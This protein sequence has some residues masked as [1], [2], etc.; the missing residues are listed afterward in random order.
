MVLKNLGR[1]MH[2]YRKSNGW[3]QETMAWKLKCA[4]ST[5]SGIETGK[6]CPSVKTFDKICVEFE[7][8]GVD[9]HELTM[10]ENLEF[11]KVKEELILA[12]NSKGK[13]TIEKKLEKFKKYM[14]HENEEHQK[15]VLLSDLVYMLKSGMD[16]EE[17]IERIEELFPTNHETEKSDMLTG[18]HF[19]KLEHFG[20]YLK[21][22]ALLETGYL[23]KAQELYELLLNNGFNDN[24]DYYRKRCNSVSAGLAKLLIAKHDYMKA[25]KCIGYI[26][27]K[28]IKN[29]DGRV[30]FQ[31]MC[32]QQELFKEMGN[33]EG[34]KIINDFFEAAAA[35]INYFN[36]YYTITDQ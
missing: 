33:T 26:F 2:S 19:T 14:D 10:N 9:Y 35:M 8:N 23:E 11:Q 22:N 30:F 7:V 1:N 28:A 36:K 4:P 5:L 34:E 15:Y 25:E 29:I 18:Q 24:T 12:L 32:L 21:A 27:S 13:K 31:V 16:K 17:F 6:T 3:S 20:I